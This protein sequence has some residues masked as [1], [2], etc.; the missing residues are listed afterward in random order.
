MFYRYNLRRILAFF[1]VWVFISTS[2]NQTNVSAQEFLLPEPGARLHLSLPFNPAR[3]VGMTIHS[4]N[5]LRFDFLIDRGKQSLSGN[6]KKEEYKKLIKYFLAALTIPDEDQWVN[7]SPYEKNRII[8]GNFGL[9]EMGRDLLG[10]DYILKQITSSLMY[11]EDDLGRRFWKRIYQEVS[12][13]YKTTNVWVNT[14]NKVWIIPDKAIVYES[15]N[16]VYVLCNHLKVMLE[17]DY[18]AFQKHNVETPFMASHNKDAINRVSTTI[19]KDIIL[20]EIEKE[21]N[22]GENF[23][24]L[25]QIYNSMILAAWYKKALQE[26]LLGKVYANKAKVK[27]IDQDP[28]TNEKIYQRYLKA[29]QKGV[30]NY[31]KDDVDKYTHEVIPRKYFSGGALAYIHGVQPYSSAMPAGTVGVLSNGILPVEVVRG[32]GSS[33]AQLSNVDCAMVDFIP[34]NRDSAMPAHEE[35][36]KTALARI[37][38]SPLDIFFDQKISWRTNETYGDKYRQWAAETGMDMED[39]NKQIASIILGVHFAPSVEDF[40]EYKGLTLPRHLKN[41]VKDILD[42][43]ESAY[44]FN[45][46]PAKMMLWK[47]GELAFAQEKDQMLRDWKREEQYYFTEFPLREEIPED[48]NH[49]ILDLAAGPRAAWYFYQMRGEKVIAVDRSYFIEAFLNAAKEHFNASGIIVRRADI[50]DPETYL[51]ESAYRYVRMCNIDMYVEG[52]PQRVYKE[53]MEKVMPGG[54]ISIETAE[55]HDG[56]PDDRT[57]AKAIQQQAELTEAT[58]IRTKRFI[59]SSLAGEKS[60]SRL[61]TRGFPVQSIESFSHSSKRD[62]VFEQM[63]QIP[64]QDGEHGLSRQ[65]YDSLLAQGKDGYTYISYDADGQMSGYMIAVS[66]EDSYGP[67]V[68]VTD[69]RLKSEDQHNLEIILLQFLMAITQKAIENGTDRIIFDESIVKRYLIEGKILGLGFCEIYQ[70][71]KCIYIVNSRVLFNSIKDF[72]MG[73]TRSVSQYGGIDLNRAHLNFQIQR[74]GRRALLKASLRDMAQLSR[75]QG[76]V[77]DFLE[78]RYAGNFPII[79]ELQ[80]KL[81]LNHENIRS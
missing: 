50:R 23:A 42:F 4:D 15:G 73:A 78:I 25:R 53:I 75:I 57:S 5:A 24:N 16:T 54:K 55:H 35:Y 8:K 70:R 31:I 63:Q 30:F 17:K 45:F 3:L 69:F 74:N 66:E 12:K 52:I 13:Q 7:L 33:A 26:S 51:K 68:H 29:F 40:W 22:E 49:Y 77:P 60:Y 2:F 19:V 6:L 43:M 79:K 36:N 61:C 27:G 47:F 64:R 32:G 20:P 14:F 1:A 11:P 10:Q 58:W 34:A 56:T 65:D 18:L 38:Q 48:S 80:Q 41:I 72:A 46:E 21:V 37:H 71:K 44:S 76:L 59:D 9:T 39:L 81:N 28:T 62:Q 67:K